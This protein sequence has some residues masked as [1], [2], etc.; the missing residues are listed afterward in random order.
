MRPQ[1]DDDDAGWRTCFDRGYTG[2]REDY[3]GSGIFKSVRAEMVK[4]VAATREHSLLE[5]GASPRGTIALTRIAKASAYLSGRTYV[6]PEDVSAATK[7]VLLH[8]I[9]LSAKARINHA[10]KDGV[11]DSILENVPK[12]SPKRK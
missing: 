5:L 10:T 3:D 12:P 2:S 9:K 4:L 7:D 6:T 11:M 8:R 1:G